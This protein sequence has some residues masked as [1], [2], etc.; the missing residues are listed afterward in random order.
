MDYLAR[1]VLLRGGT[2][3]HM[4]CCIC[5]LMC[6]LQSVSGSQLGFLSSELHGMFQI[7]LDDAQNFLIF[8]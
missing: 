7:R 6:T 1:W 3:G 4:R 2:R 8:Q 5:L